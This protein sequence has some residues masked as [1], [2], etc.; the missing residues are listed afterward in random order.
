MDLWDTS[1]TDAKERKTNTFW[2]CKSYCHRIFT[3]DSR[4]YYENGCQ[5]KPDQPEKE[6]KALTEKDIENRTNRF[7]DDMLHVKAKC[8]EAKV[9]FL[10]YLTT[11]SSLDFI[12][13][14]LRW[15]FNYLLWIYR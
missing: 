11:N 2:L 7:Y 8:E 15:H 12:L 3:S 10:L 5:T 9:I 6:A 1:A 4:D 13:S 14:I